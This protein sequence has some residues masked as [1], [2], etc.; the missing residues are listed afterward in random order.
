MNMGKHAVVAYCCG[1]MC[2]CLWVHSSHAQ[3]YMHMRWFGCGTTTL[4]CKVTYRARQVLVF[5]YGSSCR[6]MVS[7]RVYIS[8]TRGCLKRSLASTCVQPRS[9]AASP[10]KVSRHQKTLW[11][12]CE[13]L[14]ICPLS[15]WIETT[16]DHRLDFK[17][18]WHLYERVSLL[19]MVV[20]NEH[21]HSPGWKFQLFAPL[22]A[23]LQYLQM[24]MDWNGLPDTLIYS[25]FDRLV[26]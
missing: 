21:G 12:G 18:V 17:S 4:N 22:Y 5:S 23:T 14:L 25:S 2:F 16:P 1:Y 9:T 15:W 7:D 10:C 19:R 24:M 26:R 20:A 6:C 11:S 8:I 3:A 13:T